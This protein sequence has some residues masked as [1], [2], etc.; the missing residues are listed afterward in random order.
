MYGE[1]QEGSGEA[2]EG[3]TKPGRG[4][5][6]NEWEAAEQREGWRE[7]AGKGGGRPGDRAPWRPKP[8]A[9][10]VN[11]LSCGAR[12]AGCSGSGSPHPGRRPRGESPR[13]GPEPGRVR[14]AGLLPGECGQCG[15]LAWAPGHWRRGRPR[16]TW[17][18]RSGALA[19]ARPAP[20]SAPGPGAQRRPREPS[21]GQGGV[22]ASGE[23][24][25][26]PLAAA[27][28]CPA[29]H[30]SRIPAAEPEGEEVP[31]PHRPGTTRRRRAA[32]ARRV[33]GEGKR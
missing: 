18:L 31:P 20:H 14:S 28:R 29:G 11:A 33:K 4:N 13:S 12:P 32:G 5:G 10:L 19:G 16:G 8:R 30:G 21:A 26:A 22:P 1:P 9:R 25:R 23:C 17:G 24:A 6:C 7:D 2:S 3:R 27:A 15:A